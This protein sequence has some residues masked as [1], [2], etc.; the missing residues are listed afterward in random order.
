[1][2]SSLTSRLPKSSLPTRPIIAT[3]PRRVLRQPPGSRLT[4]GKD[5]EPA[6][7]KGSPGFRQ[8]FG[9]DD[10]IDIR[11]ADDEN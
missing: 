1:V 7:E 5:L 11:A 8:M 6:A 10:Q 4:A 2:A 9:G 3:L